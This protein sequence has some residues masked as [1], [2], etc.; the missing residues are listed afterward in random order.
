MTTP[1]EER[2][3]AN[4]SGEKILPFLEILNQDTTNSVYVM[5]GRTK[6]DLD[7]WSKTNS[8]S[9]GLSAE[10]GAFFQLPSETSWKSASTSFT[11]DKKSTNWRKLITKLFQK[12]AEEVFGSCI[13]NS[14]TM[15]TLDFSKSFDSGKV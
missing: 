7:I 2:E 6:A 1:A 5:S 10:Y 3:S 13:V 9:L 15:I 12:Y 8:Y 4:P 11:T 14:K